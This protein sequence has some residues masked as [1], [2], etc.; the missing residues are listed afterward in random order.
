MKNTWLITKKELMDYFYSPRGY[1][2]TGAMITVANWLFFKNI[3]LINQAE[4]SN[5]W[6]T[7]AFLLSLLIPAMTMGLFAEEKKNHTWEILNSLPLKIKD[8]VWGKFLAGVV[9]IL[10]TLALSLPVAATLAFLGRPAIGLL[11]GGYLGV[12]LMGLAFLSL[13]LFISSLTNQPLTA[14]LITSLILILNNLLAQFKPLTFLSLAAR[15]AKFSSGLIDIGDLFFFIT[16]ILIFVL[17]TIISQ[18]RKKINLPLINLG[19]ILV[20]INLLLTFYPSLKLDLTQDKVHSLSPI[21]KEIVRNLDDIVNIKVL[22]SPDLPVEVKPATDKLKAILAEFNRTNRRKFKVAYL[23]PA[24]DENAQAMAASLGIRPI[25][26]NQIKKDKLELQ[27]AYL[28]VVIVYGQKQMVINLDLQNMEYLIISSIKKLINEKSPTVALFSENN[29]DLQYFRQYL[30]KDYTVINADLFSKNELPPADTLIIAGLSKK[31]DDKNLNKIKEW[32]KTQKGLIVFLDRIGV[33][34]NMISQ[35]YDSTGLESL[36]AEN[37]IKIEDKLVLDG[38]AGVATFNTVD[39]RILVQYPFWPLIKPENINSRLPVMSGIDSL[40]LAW[41]SP[42]TI[43]DKILPLFTTTDKAEVTDNFNDLS[44]LTKLGSTPQQQQILGA[45]KTDDGQ[46]LAVV[47]DADFIKDNFI[48]S[49]DR[50]LYFA[51]NLVDYFSGDSSLMTIRSKAL[52]ISPLRETT[53]QEK[54]I[55]RIV[56]LVLPTVI[57]SLIA[58][59]IIKRRKLFNKQFNEE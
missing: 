29:N 5:Y 21:S 48:V 26:F 44:P 19:I 40:Q 52:R 46:K 16:W 30:S 37:G 32:L 39:G 35:R 9:F 38:S 56:N 59:I 3:F 11:I 47:G 10:F 53:D 24:K 49:N 57:L 20:L 4:M 54:L 8:I 51:L 50:N 13:G 14:F 25:Q 33:D 17:A 12:I 1:L 36:L 58:F 55:I 45:I 22:M 31:L 2:V 6:E 7:M 28:A 34:E 23:D 41:A 43:D 15:S 27:N 42:L 18:K